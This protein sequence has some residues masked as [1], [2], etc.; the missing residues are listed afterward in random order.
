MSVSAVAGMS[1]LVGTASIT[2]A[3][4]TA[5]AEAEG[6]SLADTANSAAIT[7]GT[8]LGGDG[9]AAAWATS[10]TTEATGVSAW[11]TSAGKRNP[12]PQHAEPLR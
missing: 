1:A 5:S 4:I 2:T 9:I 10:V 7:T 6:G 8:S 12:A 11:A 3:S